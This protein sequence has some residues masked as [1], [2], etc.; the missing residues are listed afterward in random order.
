MAVHNCLRTLVDPQHSCTSKRAPDRRVLGPEECARSKYVHP[1]E[2]IAKRITRRTQAVR[3]TAQNEVGLSGPT[4]VR[5]ERCVEKTIRSSAPRSITCASYAPTIPRNV[6]A[7]RTAFPS[8]S[9]L[10]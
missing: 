5:R 7:F 2:P 8:P 10:K 6:I 9:L 4:L 3:P 1:I